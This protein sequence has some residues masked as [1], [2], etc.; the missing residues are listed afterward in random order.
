MSPLR[1]LGV[2][3]VRAAGVFS[4]GDVDGVDAHAE[5][6]GGRNDELG[7]E[8]RA[9]GKSV[10]LPSLP[11]LVDFGMTNRMSMWWPLLAER[12]GDPRCLCCPSHFVAPGSKEK[13]PTARESHLLCK[14]FECFPL[15]SALRIGYLA[16]LRRR[17]CPWHLNRR[18]VVQ[19]R[20]N[21]AAARGARRRLC[22]M[23]S[24]HVSAAAKLWL[25]L[26]EVTALWRLCRYLSPPSTSGFRSPLCRC[27]D[28]C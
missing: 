13:C 15:Q 21:V 28:R 17:R 26:A 12:P 27:R 18:V 24:P 14:Q 6:A 16:R 8:V 19:R 2:E 10:L 20:Q 5:S 1:A 25:P 23:Y 11:V 4:G 9:V 22:T 3:A 7:R